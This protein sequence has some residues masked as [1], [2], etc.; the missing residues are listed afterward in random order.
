MIICTFVGHREVYDSKAKEKLKAEIERIIK[1]NDGVEFFCGGMGEFDLLCASEVRKQKRNYPD[2]DIKLYLIIPYLTQDI[3]ENAEYYRQNY[4]E[5]IRPDCLMGVHY[6]SAIQ[7][8]NRYM[9]DKSD[10]IISYIRR[11]SGGAYQSYF[12]AKRKEKNVIEL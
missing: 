10:I 1:E 8:R 6:K 11:K 4:D 2:K 9:I 7:K 5:I 12:Y 3:N